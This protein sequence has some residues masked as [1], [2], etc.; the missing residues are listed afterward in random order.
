MST[1]TY[2]RFTDPSLFRLR[3]LHQYRAALELLVRIAARL[4]LPHPAARLEPR[5]RNAILPALS[6]PHTARAAVRLDR[7]GV[8]RGGWRSEEH[9][10]ELQSLMRSSYDV[11]CL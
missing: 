5:A 4:C 11:C 6:V 8:R 1:R 7:V 10:S 9:T 3:E 2:T